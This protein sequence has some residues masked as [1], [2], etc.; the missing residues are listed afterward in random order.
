V[1]LTHAT[2]AA[3]ILV[4]PRVDVAG[5]DAEIER[6]AFR[7]LGDGDGQGERGHERRR[8]VLPRHFD[9]HAGD[10]G[11]PGLAFLPGLGRREG[12]GPCVGKEHREGSKPGDEGG[13]GPHPTG[14]A[15]FFNPSNVQCDDHRVASSAA[16]HEREDD[17]G[18]RVRTVSHFVDVGDRTKCPARYTGATLAA[19]RAIVVLGVHGF[20]DALHSLPY[21]EAEPESDRERHEGEEHDPG[22]VRAT[23]ATRRARER[24]KVRETEAR[25]VEFHRFV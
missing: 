21:V 8:R 19:L 16:A 1:D 13:H 25:A 17:R 12:P 24:V 11:D 22:G 15:V 5:V 9:V 23:P 10:H 4:V 7:K 18:L 6:A 2:G 20:H 3:V 14:A